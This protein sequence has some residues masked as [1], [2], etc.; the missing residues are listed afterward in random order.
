MKQATLTVFILLF[1]IS[2]YSAFAQKTVLIAYHSETGNTEM[3]AR[4]VADGARSVDGIQVLLK[5]SADVT[6]T[7][8]KN[9]DAIIVGSPVYNAAITPEISRFIASWPFEGSPLKDK[10]G[11][12]FVTGG[13]ISAGEELAQTGVL[14]SMLIFGMIVVG[15]PDWTQAFGASAITS[16]EPFAAGQPENIHPRFLEKGRKLGERVAQVT[17]RFSI[18]E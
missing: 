4:S 7:D 10:I 8:L 16:E 6:E 5:Q 17:L 9:A 3:M 11:A 1:F 13:G 18:A 12:V 15:G 14:Q 2:S